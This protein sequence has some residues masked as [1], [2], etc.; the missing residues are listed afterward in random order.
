VDSNQHQEEGKNEYQHGSGKF[1]CSTC[2]QDEELQ[3]FAKELGTAR[4]CNYCAKLQNS[5]VPFGRVVAEMTRHI[6]REWCAPFEDGDEF[7]R[8]DIQAFLERNHNSQTLFKRIGFS[9]PNQSL[10][11]DLLRAFGDHDW[12]KRTPERL[13]A[14]SR[15][16]HSWDTF[17]HLVRYERR[18][19]FWN[20]RATRRNFLNGEVLSPSHLL[21]EIG[22]IIN[23]AQLIKHLPIGQLMW[24]VRAFR[25]TDL[26]RGPDRF[27]SPPL[28]KATQPNRMSP[29]GV[30][31]FYGAE[32][33]DTAR[34]EVVGTEGHGKLLAGVQFK[35]VVPLNILDLTAPSLGRS[36]FK[37]AQPGRHQVI[38]FLREFA[39]DLSRPISGSNREHIDYVPTQVFTEFVRYVMKAPNRAPIHGIKY[40][41]SWDQRPCYVIFATQDQCLRPPEFPRATGHKPRARQMLDFVPESLKTLQIS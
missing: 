29:A 27:T 1:V 11:S 26:A 7:N 4:L 40:F 32:H 39:E 17:Q 41:S 2:I 16:I 20:A 12:C 30:P 38:E 25:P 18:Y 14:K 9:V 21:R 22:A 19:T 34:R 33:L 15:W 37:D 28:K 6:L 10:M 36:Y 13:G 5:V 35:T 3:K 24:R 8:A 31:M 23:K